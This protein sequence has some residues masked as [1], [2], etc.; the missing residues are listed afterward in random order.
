MDVHTVQGWDKRQN[1][2]EHDDFLLALKPPLLLIFSVIGTQTIP[3][4]QFFVGTSVI[5][6]QN[7]HLENNTAFQ[8]VGDQM[9]SPGQQSWIWA[10]SSQNNAAL[11][12]NL[13]PG[14]NQSAIQRLVQLANCAR[15]AVVSK[16]ITSEGSLQ[17][18]LPLLPLYFLGSQQQFSSCHQ[19]YSQGKM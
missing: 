3:L 8:R 17:A 10:F 16:P 11:E 18:T 13:I 5:C 6:T 2:I 15:I 9:A 1:D 19:H 12:Q 4:N 14:W 7:P